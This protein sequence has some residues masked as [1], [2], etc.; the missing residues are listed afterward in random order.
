M[1][2]D[3]GASGIKG[4]IVDLNTGELITERIKISTPSPSTPEA[5]AEV[6]AEIVTQS[7]YDGEWIG[8]GFPSVVKHGVCLSAANID[9]SW[10]G[11]NIET[12]V[13]KATGRKV[14]ALNDA[15]AAGLAEVRYGRGKD[16]EGTFLLITIGSGLGSALFTGGRLVSNTEFGHMIMH[17]MIAEHYVSNTTRKQLNLSWEEFGTRFNE[18]LRIIERVLTPDLIALGGGV[19]NDYDLY[20]GYFDI[21]TPVT[22]AMMFNHAGIIGAAMH[23]F[24][25]RNL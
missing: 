2:I 6:I 20:A 10:V 24:E 14:L 9:K 23:A 1:G 4:A 5:V 13:S 11:T 17:D 22:T 7:G 3:V 25:N 8:C 16:V 21:E 18:F 15:D 12:V 19:S